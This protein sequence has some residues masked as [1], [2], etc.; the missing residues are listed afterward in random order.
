MY[1]Y[2]AIFAVGVIVGYKM[3]RGCQHE[4]YF[5]KLDDMIGYQKDV[6]TLSKDLSM[7]YKV[8]TLEELEDAKDK[9]SER[10]LTGKS[11]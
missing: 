3:K 8:E 11:N 4:K 5:S 2:I 1:F 6:M 7:F 9:I 10:V